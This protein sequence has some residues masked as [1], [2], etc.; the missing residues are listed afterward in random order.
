MPTSE[1]LPTGYTPGPYHAV[2]NEQEQSWDVYGP[3]GHGYLGGLISRA[4]ADLL[5]AAPELVET[6]RALTFERDA[7]QQQVRDGEMTILEGE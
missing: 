4:D 3:V 1:D 2:W 5:A 7:L 6:V